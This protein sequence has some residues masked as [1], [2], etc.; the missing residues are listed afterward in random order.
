MD[1]T[2]LLP[3][4]YYSSPNASEWETM[5]DVSSDTEIGDA[6]PFH[7]DA[8]A[9]L[10]L[11]TMASHSDDLV[12][13]S[14]PYQYTNIDS[15]PALVPYPLSPL[16]DHDYRHNTFTP[17]PS[18]HQPAD[19]NDDQ[20][21]GS[22]IPPI[23]YDSEYDV[24]KQDRPLPHVRIE[25]HVP[26]VNDFMVGAVHPLESDKIAPPAQPRS[27]SPSNP[28]AIDPNNVEANEDEE[29][30]EDSN[31]VCSRQRS[32]DLMP[33]RVKVIRLKD[34]YER[35]LPIENPRCLDFLP[36][37]FVTTHLG[38]E[39]AW[40]VL[41]SYQSDR[42]MS[43]SPASSQELDEFFIIELVTRGGHR[44]RQPVVYPE[45]IV[46]YM[47]RQDYEQFRNEDGRLAQQD[48]RTGLA[49]FDEEYWEYMAEQGAI[50]AEIDAR[51]VGTE[52]DDD[53]ADDP[54]VEPPEV[55]H[56]EVDAP[57]E[58]DAPETAFEAS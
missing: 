48:G 54:E 39:R 35:E 31:I 53:E 36:V 2:N 24:V 45:D 17:P 8:L 40:N 50:W 29:D 5:T 58:V 11:P 52:V 22:P 25:R 13:S 1:A 51:D 44:G 21:P 30:G 20:D 38:I 27:S 18:S 7:P 46:P 42:E 47:S 16:T 3:Q 28:F 4:E 10:T 9:D 43:G 6:P 34:L 15:A 26:G 57:F 19:R 33:F 12:P 23:V 37:D 49:M 55:D 32:A 41:D 56:P 14:S